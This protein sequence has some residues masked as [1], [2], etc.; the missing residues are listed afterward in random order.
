MTWILLIAGLAAGQNKN[1]FQGNKDAIEVGKASFRIFCSPCHGLGGAGGRAPDLTTG[2]YS[3]GEGDENLFRVISNGSE[4]TEMP[5]YSERT[6]ADGIWRI[7]A[8]L[9][10]VSG[11]P[12]PA[13]SGDR[14]NGEKIFWGKGSC[15]ACHRVTGKGGRLGPDLTTAG[16]M[17]SLAY[18]KESLTDPDATLSPGYNTITVVTKDGKTIKGVQKGYDGFSAQFMDA[19]ENIRSYLREDVKSMRREFKSMMP[20]TKLPEKEM[21]DLLVYLVSLRGGQTR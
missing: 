20:A 19:G 10:S 16:R 11:K 2:Q 7:V 3:V 15:G 17:R 14:M 8:Y 4:G 18:L 6:D 9:R 1:P 21:N 5:A 12:V 13:V